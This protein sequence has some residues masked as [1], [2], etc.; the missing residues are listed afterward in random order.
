MLLLHGNKVLVRS[1]GLL[2]VREQVLMQ[3]AP[4]APRRQKV[5]QLRNIIES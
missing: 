4:L 5:V 1:I 2:R 3:G